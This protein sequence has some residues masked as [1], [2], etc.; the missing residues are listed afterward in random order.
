MLRC[1]FTQ[2]ETPFGQKK[3]QQEVNTQLAFDVIKGQKT[4]EELASEY[5]V[6]VNQTSMC[7]KHLLDTA[8]ALLALGNIKTPRRKR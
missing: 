8:P 3:Q 5:V 1:I 7:K 2:Q 6:H 4:M